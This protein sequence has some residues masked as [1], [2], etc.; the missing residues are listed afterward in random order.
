MGLPLPR[1][2]PLSLHDGACGEWRGYAPLCPC[3]SGGVE[4]DGTGNKDKKRQTEGEKEE[5]EL[6]E[7]KYLEMRRISLCSAIQASG[8]EL[9]LSA[10]DFH[11]DGGID[12][13]GGQMALSFSV[14]GWSQ[15]LFSIKPTRR[16]G[17]PLSAA[18]CEALIEC[19]RVIPMRQLPHVARPA[20]VVPGSILRRM[21][22]SVGRSGLANE[23]SCPLLTNPVPFISSPCAVTGR[24][25]Q[26]MI[27][28]PWAITG[29]KY[30]EWA[31][32]DIITPANQAVIS[33]LSLASYLTSGVVW[34][35]GE[36]AAVKLQF[37]LT[38]AAF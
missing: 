29:A 20:P 37:T 27:D 1:K 38:K 24:S 17:F 11:W 12:A 5:N 15:E 18:L 22:L 32:Q 33:T 2:Q 8:W 28:S 36:L 19:E 35:A 16:H 34:E 7:L 4:R 10:G 26:P 23:H 6:P 21:F 14:G 30:K 3:R 13:R 31:A 9:L 25:G